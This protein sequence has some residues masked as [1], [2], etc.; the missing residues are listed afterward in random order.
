MDK[1]EGVVLEHGTKIRVIGNPVGLPIN[2][3]EGTVERLSFTGKMVVVHLP[4]CEG[5]TPY[6]HLFLYPREVEVVE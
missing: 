1:S 2:G 6:Y 5:Q 3:R 4:A